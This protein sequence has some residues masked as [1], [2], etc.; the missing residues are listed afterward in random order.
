MAAK[1]AVIHMTVGD[2]NDSSRSKQQQA[3]WTMVTIIPQTN[4]CFVLYSPLYFF[5][6][7]FASTRA[8]S[9]PKKNQI[10]GKRKNYFSVLFVVCR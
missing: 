6:I 2:M 1:V 4:I 5:H 10:F 8:K 7:M 9:F 3:M